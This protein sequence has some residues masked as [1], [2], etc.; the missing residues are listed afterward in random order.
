MVD[1]RISG[2]FK[3]FRYIYLFSL[4]L[5]LLLSNTFTP[6]IGAPLFNFK[7]LT[8]EAKVELEIRHKLEINGNPNS[9]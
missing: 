5:L 6:F 4:E 1:P 3:Y 8:A 7:S 2:T 9:K